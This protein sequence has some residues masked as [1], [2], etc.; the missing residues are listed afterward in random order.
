MSLVEWPSMLARNSGMPMPASWWIMVC[1]SAYICLR[2]ARSVSARDASSNWSNF[3][4]F[5]R[6]SFQLASDWKNCVSSVS[7]LGRGLTLPNPT[8]LLSQWLDQ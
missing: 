4:L 5:Q 2:L 1:M 6:N 8:G 7:A 3:W